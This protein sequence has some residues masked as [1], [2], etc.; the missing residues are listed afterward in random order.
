MKS[1]SWLMGAL[2]APALLA[3]T[4]NAEKVAY[5]GVATVPVDPVTAAQL[6][7]PEGVG[8]TVVQ[9]AEDGVVKDKLANYD[10]LRKFD[11]QILTSPDQLAVLVRGHKPGDTVKLAFIHKGKEETVKVQLG[12]TEMSRLLPRG[13]R[14][15][16]PMMQ[17]YGG[18]PWGGDFNRNMQDLQRQ[19][20][21]LQRQWQNRPQDDQDALSVPGE[22]EQAMPPSKHGRG[23]GQTGPRTHSFQESH[24]TSVVTDS[25]D[26][27]TVTITD[28]DGEKTVRVEENGKVIVDNKPINSA[29]QFKALPEK[30]RDRVN[31]IQKQY[32]MESNPQ[33]QPEGRG[34]NIAL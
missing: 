17:P 3:V 1:L 15:A 34:P 22:D 10:I 24:S 30:V 13:G 12:G 2:V 14:H 20:E 9:V 21:E 27:L 8:L 19:M 26:G 16:W 18:T 7:L 32:K 31:D 23:K 6:D 5:L 28:R 25:H 4:A 29:E 11:E 33:P